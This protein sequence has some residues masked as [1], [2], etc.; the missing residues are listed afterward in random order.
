[1]TRL[2]EGEYVDRL[3]ATGTT[4]SDIRYLG[5]AN[6]IIN[7]YIASLDS[8]I[9][10]IDTA[11]HY[12]Y[13]IESRA[14][15]D[16]ERNIEDYSASANAGKIREIVYNQGRNILKDTKEIE[17]PTSDPKLTEYRLERTQ[18]LH[19]ADSLEQLRQWLVAED[20]RRRD[21]LTKP[22]YEY[23]ATNEPIDISHYIFEKEKQNY[24][25]ELWRKDYMDIDL[26][27]GRLEFPQIQIYETAFYYN[28]MATQIDF[29][30][31]NSSYQIYSGG[32]GYY[33]P[34]ST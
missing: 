31:L 34:E 25:D 27:T 15:T 19:E 26:D 7:R 22:I 17:D 28:Y 23:F 20:R 24:Y 29:S 18:M 14:V 30:F 2:A 16:Y 3:A 9:S 11:T 5:N 10:Y 4:T 33:N 32:S 12:R 1:M 13:Y 6:G 21:T 8:T